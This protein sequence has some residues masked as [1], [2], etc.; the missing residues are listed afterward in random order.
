MMAISSAMSTA[1]VTS[2]GSRVTRLSCCPQCLPELLPPGSAWATAPWV[3]KSCCYL[4]L[5]ELLLHGPVCA[6]APCSCL[7]YCSMGLPELLLP[8]AA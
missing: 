4:W 3:Y 5:L 2:S 8:A 7:S 6:A 1:S